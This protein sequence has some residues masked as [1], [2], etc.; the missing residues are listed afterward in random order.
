MKLIYN[1]VL[2]YAHLNKVFLWKICS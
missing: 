1:Y 2:S